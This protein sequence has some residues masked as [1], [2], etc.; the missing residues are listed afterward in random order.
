MNGRAAEW[1]LEI[2]RYIQQQREKQK[3]FSGEKSF[4]GAC[5]LTQK[6]SDGI[7]EM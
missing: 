7:T 5:S 3:S 4:S 6:R 2:W 1:A